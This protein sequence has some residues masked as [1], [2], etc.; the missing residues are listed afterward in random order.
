MKCSLLFYVLCLGIGIA[1]CSPEFTTTS[2]PDDSIYGKADAQSI[3][4]SWLHTNNTN[5]YTLSI[6]MDI[7]K[8]KI[9]YDEACV[10]AN[11]E[12]GIRTVSRATVGKGKITL[13]DGISGNIQNGDL[14]C[15]LDFA[16]I[17]YPVAISGN[18]LTL[19]TPAGPVKFERMK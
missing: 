15:G 3:L 4:G 6:R 18:T 8:T 9:R 12:V 7:E 14:R 11:T 1:A 13:V 17:E 19:K 16:A 10:A 2:A 5:T